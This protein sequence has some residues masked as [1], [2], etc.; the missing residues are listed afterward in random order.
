L[1]RGEVVEQ[2]P[3]DEVLDN[4]GHEYT[5]RLIASIPGAA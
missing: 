1:H 2:G 4:P 3:V 5:A